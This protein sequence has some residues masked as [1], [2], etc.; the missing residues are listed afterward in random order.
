[1]L[2]KTGLVTLAVAVVAFV[3]G[4]NGMEVVGGEGQVHQTINAALLLVTTLV[5]AFRQTTKPPV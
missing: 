2:N 1:M 5:A 3:L 4:P